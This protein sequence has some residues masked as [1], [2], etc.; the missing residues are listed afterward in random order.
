MNVYAKQPEFQVERK[1]ECMAYIDKWTGKRIVVLL[2]SQRSNGPYT[3][4]ITTA[5]AFAM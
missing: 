2:V 5:M 3:S 4:K 1:P